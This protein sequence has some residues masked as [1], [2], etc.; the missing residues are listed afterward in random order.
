[1]RQQKRRS[2]TLGEWVEEYLVDVVSKKKNPREDRRYLK[3]AV[4]AFGNKPLKELKVRDIQVLFNRRSDRPASANR[5]LASVRACLQAAWRNEL[6]E[7][8][9]AMKIKPNSETAA[10][11]RFLNDEEFQRLQTAIDEIEDLFTRTAFLLLINTGA[12]LS[13]VLKAKWSDF[14]FEN[15]VWYLLSPKAGKSQTIR[16]TTKMV[17][18]LQQLPRLGEYMISG[19]NPNQP[20]PDLKKP[21]KTLQERTGLTDVGIHDLRRT[22]GKQISMKEGILVASKLLRHSDIRVTQKHYTPL[23]DD[24][25]L[26]AMERRESD[27]EK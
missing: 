3:E 24:E 10:R 4:D 2:E 26:K 11:I 13:E 6:I 16:L 18:V 7:S 17:D 25:L 8:N 27:Y 1:M 21:W 19:R 15:R 23:T 12:R 14:D 22:F 9:P 20:R 5:W